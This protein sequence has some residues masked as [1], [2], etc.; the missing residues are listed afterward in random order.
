MTESHR[1]RG[2]LLRLESKGEE[3]CFPPFPNFYSRGY[4]VQYKNIPLALPSDGF[5]IYVTG[6]DRFIEM[7]A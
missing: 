1:V 7:Q 5:C 4:S 6:A 3:P 2:K